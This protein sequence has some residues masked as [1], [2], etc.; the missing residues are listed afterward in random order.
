MAKTNCQRRAATALVRTTLSAH[1]VGARATLAKWL[2]YVCA[3]VCIHVVK[4][5]RQV[6]ALDASAKH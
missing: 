6:H 3:Y 5:F 4:Q 2:L 1:Q